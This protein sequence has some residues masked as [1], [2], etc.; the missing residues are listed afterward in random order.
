MTAAR[1]LPGA[2]ARELPARDYQLLKTASADLVEAAGRGVRAAG[3]TRVGQQRLSEYCSKSE[4]HAEDFFPADVI[5]DLEA[6]AGPILTTALAELSGHKLV[7]M[8][9]VLPSCS[10]VA[11]LCKIVTES[12]EAVAEISKARADHTITPD[13]IPAIRARLHDAIVAFLEFQACLEASQ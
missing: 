10:D 3:R 5:A 1:S 6:H 9:A 2:K 12:A 13:E 7:K 4:E 11:G 8:P